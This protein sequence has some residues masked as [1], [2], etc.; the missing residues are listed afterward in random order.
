MIQGRFG[1]DD[2]LF[3]EIELIAADGLELPIE[4]LLDTGFS[5]WLT[6]N[7]QDLEGLDW[8]YVR[9]QTLRTA[10]GEA[11]FDIYVGKVRI[12][13]QDFDI[14]VYA[15]N[16]VTEVLLGRQW[17]KNRRLVVDLPLGVLTLL[18]S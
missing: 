15:G 12:D 8:V 18:T 11:E 6:I 2:E 3:F 4:A 5:D 10:S 17:L 13:G 14:P 9:K 7:S 1:D 16:E